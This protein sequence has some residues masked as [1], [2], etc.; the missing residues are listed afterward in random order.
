MI[1]MSPMAHLGDSA[2]GSPWL[3][4]RMTARIQGGGIEN[5]REASA[6]KSPIRSAATAIPSEFGS[7]AYAALTSPSSTTAT[8]LHRQSRRVTF[9]RLVH[10]QTAARNWAGAEEDAERTGCRTVALGLKELR[11]SVVF[12]RPEG[13]CVA[14]DRGCWERAEIATV[15]RVLGLPVHQEHLVVRDELAALPARQHSSEVI[16][17]ER[18][19]VVTPSM[20]IV[21]P[22]RQTN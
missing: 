7:S 13:I 3:S 16:A 8:E 2:R 22:V 4:T 11:M 10:R 18:W 9:N 19:P 6:T 12:L 14:D 5:R 15:E 17:V 21:G 1:C 20:V